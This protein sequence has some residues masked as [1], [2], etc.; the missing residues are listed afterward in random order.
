[1]AE[2]FEV[3]KSTIDKEGVSIA[4]NYP[5]G[6]V[7]FLDLDTSAGQTELYSSDDDLIL[8]ELLTLDDSPRAPLYEVLFGIGA[9]T[10]ND[11]GRYTMA[12][13]L[14]DVRKIFSKG[15]SIII[16]DYSP[17]GDS[18]TKRG[19]IFVTDVTV[20]EQQF[21]KASGIRFVV[22]TGKVVES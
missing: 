12:S 15:S 22:V 10:T 7:K 17:G 13:L 16:R 3:L 19:D 9:K 6:P 8:W 14:G 2:F 4:N 1:M 18:V 21:D 20:S 11:P 5:G